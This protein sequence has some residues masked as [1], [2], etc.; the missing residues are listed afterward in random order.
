MM[1]QVKQSN[2][3]NYSKLDSLAEQVSALFLYYWPVLIVLGLLCISYCTYITLQTADLG[4]HIIN[5]RELLS[6]NTNLLYTNFF[7]FT[8]T[9]HAFVNHHWLYGVIVF[10]LHKLFGFSGL[11]IFNTTINML[12]FICSILLSKFLILKVAQASFSQ[13]HMAIF[14]SL[15]ALFAVPFFV[16][17]TEVRPESL[18]LLFYAYFFFAAEKIHYKT[19]QQHSIKQMFQKNVIGISTLAILQIIWTSTHLFFIFGPLLFGY[20][21]FISVIS[22]LYK[23][24]KNH[25]RIVVFWTV[26]TAV[27]FVLPTLSPHGLQ[28]LLAPFTIFNSYAYKVAE[29]QS[30]W[31]MISYGVK[32]ISIYS[33]SLLALGTALVILLLSLYKK[34]YLLV[35]YAL[36]AVIFAV[37]ANSIN[38]MTSFF[39]ITMIPVLA[40]ILTQVYESKFQKKGIDFE[41]SMHVLALT[42]ITLLCFGIVLFSGIFIPRKPIGIGQLPNSQRAAEFVISNTVMGPFFN[43]YDSGGYFTYYFYPQFQPFIDNRP[44]AYS[45]DFLQNE[46]LQALQDEKTWQE[47]TEKYNINSIFFYRHDQVDGAQSFLYQRVLDDEWVPVYIDSIFIIFVK[48]TPKNSQLI[49]EFEIPQ[50]AFLL[51]PK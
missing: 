12:G 51:K 5:G 29:N 11:S 31:F 46:Y 13:K 42:I 10:Y 7:S 2:Q 1:I 17:R 16:H 28:G 49:S 19:T 30:S 9:E 15:S 20:Q 27:F 21:L 8:Q 18:S 40:L 41:N 50:E 38:R 36:L 34:Q 48:D 37:L 43:N 23:K 25:T 35:K 4:R 44:E 24:T 32:G 39:G 22:L 6:G 14:I 45:A 33:Y 47:I 3:T 26:L